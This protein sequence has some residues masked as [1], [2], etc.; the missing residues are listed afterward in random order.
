MTKRN[1]GIRSPR[2]MIRLRACWAVHPP[3]GW[4]VT[5]RTCTCRVFTSMTNSTYRRLRKIVSTWKRSQASRP[6]AAAR[7][8]GPS[9]HVRSEPAPGAQRHRLGSPGFISGAIVA[10]RVHF[11]ER[12][13]LGPVEDAGSVRHLDMQ[14]LAKAHRQFFGALAL[15]DDPVLL[16][17]RPGEVTE[18]LIRFVKRMVADYPNK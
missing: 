10:K 18:F 16:H 6:S 2:S 5:P 3:S 9:F 13:E 12:A 11:G 15:H 4:A 7:P 17:D 8:T 1:E 14:F